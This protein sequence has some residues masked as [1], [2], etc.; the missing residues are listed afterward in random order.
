MIEPVTREAPGYRG[1]TMMI[2]RW[3]DVAF[4]HWSV[5]PGAVTPYL[6]PGV[7]PDVHPEGVTWVGLIAFRMVGAGPLRGPGIPWLGTFPETNVRLYGVDERGVRG[8]VFRSL[9]AARLPVVL[10]ARA[11]FGLPYRWARMRI[12]PDSW[13][14]TGPH[15]SHLRLRVGDPLVPG[16]LEH[17]L[18]ARWGL[19][20][21]HL[22]IDW[23]VPNVHETWPLHTAEVLELDDDL[24]A[25]AGFGD[26]ATRPP[27][28][29]AWS[30]GVSVRFGFPRPWRRPTCPT[31]R[32]RT[33]HRGLLAR[34]RRRM[35]DTSQ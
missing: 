18:T 13:T 16:E 33:T 17:F 30:P 9:D 12:G 29:V 27:D 26:L 6:P 5:D 19:H 14:T 24:V 22:G 1:P 23:Y 7:R 10:G 3:C 2:Q 35:T 31:R 8:I 4:L 34:I 20:E 32:A 21:R 11:A 15:H 25:A 28:H